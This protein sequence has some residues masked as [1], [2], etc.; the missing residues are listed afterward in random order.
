MTL[1]WL[2]SRF[3]RSGSPRHS[4]RKSVDEDVAQIRAHQNVVVG[5]QLELLVDVLSA[6]RMPTI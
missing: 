3:R 6:F 1:P 4:D 2:A 5:E